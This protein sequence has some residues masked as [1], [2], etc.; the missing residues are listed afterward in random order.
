M[1]LERLLIVVP[2]SF[3]NKSKGHVLFVDIA[4]TIFIFTNTPTHPLTVIFPLLFS[5]GNFNKWTSVNDYSKIKHFC[6]NESIGLLLKV[7]T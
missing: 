3:T 6:N 7:T 5:H 4:L 2:Y 1:V